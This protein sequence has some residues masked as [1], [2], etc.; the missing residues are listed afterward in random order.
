MILKKAE[1]YCEERHYRFTEPR[2]HVLTILAKHKKP[3]GAYDIL[4]QL[5]AY[6]DKPKPPTA[7]RAIEFWREH[8]FVHKI[9]SLNAYVICCEG[10]LHH[11]THF[12]ICG[13]CR[14]VQEIHHPVADYPALPQGFEVTR[15]MTETYGT[16]G[17]CQEGR[18]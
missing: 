12:L 11:D 6:I 4:E 17:S 2:R 15:H 18:P 5:G 10:H 9:E 7:Y 1:R 8:G 3:M 13:N 16:C 14:H